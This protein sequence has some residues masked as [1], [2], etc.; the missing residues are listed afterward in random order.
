MLQSLVDLLRQ[1]VAELHTR[2][3]ELEE[4]ISD[5]DRDTHRRL[6]IL[7]DMVGRN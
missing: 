2:V 1:E 7:E 6:D 3:L 5:V 4:K